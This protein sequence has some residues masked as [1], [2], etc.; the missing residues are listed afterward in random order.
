MLQSTDKKQNLRFT[1]SYKTSVLATVSLTALTFVATPSLADIDPL[2]D[3][4]FADLAAI[5]DQELS[6]LRGGFTISTPVGLVDIGIGISDAVVT[7]LAGLDNL[8]GQ[9]SDPLQGLGPQISQT[10]NE[11]IFEAGGQP[12]PPSNNNASN[13]AP[14]AQQNAAA[15]SAVSNA[16]AALG[17]ALEPVVTTSTT[18]TNQSPTTNTA[19]TSQGGGTAASAA[20]SQSAVTSLTALDT[21]AQGVVSAAPEPPTE[22]TLATKASQSDLTNPQPANVN[23]ADDLQVALADQGTTRIT[24]T[25]SA[26]TARIIENTRDNVMISQVVSLNLRFQ[27]FNRMSTMNATRSLVTAIESATILYSLR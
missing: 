21:P 7:S 25:G 16:T 14:A 15:N 19:A 13:A 1:R 9:I 22:I 12:L 24:T 5:P 18:P 26:G 20:T 17:Q 27:D 11:A 2:A 6:D 3:D 10:V 23:N 4:P 8:G